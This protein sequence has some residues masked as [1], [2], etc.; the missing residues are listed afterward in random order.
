MATGHYSSTQFTCGLYSLE[1]KEMVRR[2]VHSLLQLRPVFKMCWRFLMGWRRLEELRLREDLPTALRPVD[3]VEGEHNHVFVG[4][5]LSVYAMRKFCLGLCHLS[6]VDSLNEFRCRFYNPLIVE[7][8]CPANTRWVRLA[9]L[10]C[11]CHW[12]S[13][14]III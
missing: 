4:Q 7:A 3:A 8:I 1:K 11:S 5:F 6:R 10:M 9:A 2:F 12:I 14:V 13:D